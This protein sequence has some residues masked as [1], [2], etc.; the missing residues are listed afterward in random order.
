[1]IEGLVR[2]MA[3][4]PAVTGP[5]NLGNPQEV[6]VLDLAQRIIRL[7]GSR[8]RLEFR[9]LPADDPRRRRP[10]IRK[11]EL[12]LAWQPMTNLEQGLSATIEHFRYVLPPTG[13]LM[14]PLPPSA[15]RTAS[16]G[17]PSDLTRG[18]SGRPDE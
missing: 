4:G 16:H 14:V 5:I 6:S 18:G 11:A 13:L 1:M 15:L 2:L 7:T 3:S 12:V 9:P 10:D 17:A 8:S